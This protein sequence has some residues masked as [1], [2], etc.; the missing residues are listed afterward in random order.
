MDSK[1]SLYS[2]EMKNKLGHLII[3]GTKTFALR[4]F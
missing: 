3:Y 1:K 4:L 2:F